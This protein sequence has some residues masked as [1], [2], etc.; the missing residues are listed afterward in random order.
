MSLLDYLSRKRTKCSAAVAKERLQI[1][2][3]HEHAAANG[4]D[5]LPALQRDLLTVVCKYT[6]VNLDDISVHIER[7]GNI[8]ILELNVILS[9]PCVKT[10]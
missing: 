1:I 9:E 5:Y 2:L 6:Q 10:M 4:Y 3:A 7:D 8:D